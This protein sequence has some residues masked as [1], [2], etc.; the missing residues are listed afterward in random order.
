MIVDH[1]ERGAQDLV[2]PQDFGDASLQHW[3]V[4]R[5]QE[6]HSHVY[7][8]EW[9]IRLE[10][11]QEP[12]SLLGEG[13]RCRSRFCAAWN[14]F[15]LRLPTSLLTQKRFQDGSVLSGKF[16]H[17]FGLIPFTNT[18]EDFSRKGAK[19]QSAA[20]FLRAF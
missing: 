13:Q 11:I 19:A 9:A 7:V 15:G 18:S 16:Q 5:P 3:D 14:S 1:S 2:P 12:H 20:A 8:V 10:L 4:E 6:F 17:H